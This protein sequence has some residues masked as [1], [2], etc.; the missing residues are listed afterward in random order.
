MKEFQRPPASRRRFGYGAC[1]QSCGCGRQFKVCYNVSPV[2]WHVAART[3]P[4]RHCSPLYEACKLTDR[5]HLIWILLENRTRRVWS[6]GLIWWQTQVKEAIIIQR[7]KL[8]VWAPA[9]S[10]DLI[11]PNGRLILFFSFSRW[12]SKLEVE[13]RSWMQ[14]WAGSVMPVSFIDE[15]TK[16]IQTKKKTTTMY[17]SNTHK[18]ILSVSLSHR[19][20]ASAMTQLQRCFFVLSPLWEK[21]INPHKHLREKYPRSDLTNFKRK[22]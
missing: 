18:H 4:Q 8:A 11:W 20:S 3:A 9:L 19:H 5:L 2:I 7:Q 17:D 10:L 21:S 6:R 16:K 14:S 15:N 12:I 22:T 1:R 13:K